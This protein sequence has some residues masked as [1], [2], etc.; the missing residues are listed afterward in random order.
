MVCMEIAVQ[1]QKSHILYKNK[2]ILWH[3]TEHVN[4][5]IKMVES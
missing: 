3:V 4:K 5:H 1:K 2:G